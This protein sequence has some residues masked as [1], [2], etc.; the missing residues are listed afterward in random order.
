MFEKAS[1][2]SLHKWNGKTNIIISLQNLPLKKGQDQRNVEDIFFNLLTLLA[3]LAFHALI[4]SNYCKLERFW[5]INVHTFNSKT[6]FAFQK[7]HWVTQDK[8]ATWGDQRLSPFIFAFYKWFATSNCILNTIICICNNFPSF[9][10][11]RTRS[12]KNHLSGLK[13]T[14]WL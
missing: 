4:V 14:N 13:Q 5:I 7:W 10:I 9:L 1:I 3:H 12:W 11:F 2:L 8:N 6:R